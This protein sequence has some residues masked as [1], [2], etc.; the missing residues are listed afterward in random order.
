MTIQL[1]LSVTG[2]QLGRALARDPEE[3]GYALLAIF[4]ED[5]ADLGTNAAYALT[6]TEIDTVA[7]FLERLAA[8]FRAAA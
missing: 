2:G 6:G 8:Q 7:D 1:E 3:F 4:E 5:V